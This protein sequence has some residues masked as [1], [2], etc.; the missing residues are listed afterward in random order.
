MAGTK[1]ASSSCGQLKERN[2]RL[3]VS[4]HLSDFDKMTDPISDLSISKGLVEEQG[5][6]VVMCGSLSLWEHN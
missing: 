6:T 1:T 4:L 2:L 5:R 3:L